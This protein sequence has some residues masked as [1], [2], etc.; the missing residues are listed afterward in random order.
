MK[1]MFS[2]NGLKIFISITA[3]LVVIAG[4]GSNAGSSAGTSMVTIPEP[5]APN[6]ATLT[7]DT[8]LLNADGSALTDLAGYKVYYGTQP[9]NYTNTKDVGNSNTAV[10]NNLTTGTTYFI[11]ITAYDINGNESI[12]SKE[13][14]KTP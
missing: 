9:G 13:V 3:L 6:S 4:C 1:K 2:L 12:F 14:K 11:A 10:L 5:G 7:W 8:P